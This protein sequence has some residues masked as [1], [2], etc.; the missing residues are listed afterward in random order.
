MADW[1][2]LIIAVGMMVFVFFGLG[3]FLAW[4]EAECFNK[5]QPP[6]APKA[7]VWDALFCELRV[8]GN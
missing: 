6:S 1:K 7:T 3:L 5:F 2:S 8:G 4:Q